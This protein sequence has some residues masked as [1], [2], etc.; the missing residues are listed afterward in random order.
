MFDL[1][2]FSSC[3]TCNKEFKEASFLHRHFATKYHRKRM[4]R[5]AEN[6]DAEETLT[7]LDESQEEQDDESQEDLDDLFE[8]IDDDQYEDDEVNA[9]DDDN[10]QVP[11]GEEPY[12]DFDFEEAY[13]EELDD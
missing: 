7:D 3:E 2:A 9:N 5:L 8:A 10:D 11:E 1:F 6:P 13:L 4:N 12:E